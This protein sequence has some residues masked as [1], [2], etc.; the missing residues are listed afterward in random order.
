MQTSRPRTKR[1][2]L[3][4]G[5]V[6]TWLIHQFTGGTR[7][8]TDFTNAS[9][10]GLLN[11]HTLQWDSELLNLFGIP[12]AAMP[13]LHSTSGCFGKCVA[14]HE[15]GGVPILAA[16]GDS[17]AAMF[18]HG[19]YRSGSVKA[20]YGTGSSLMALA[21]SL[22]MDTPSLART[23]AWSIEGNTQFAL[24]GNIAMTGSAIQW[25]G[26]DPS[27]TRPCLRSCQTR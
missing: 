1:E 16:V 22:P 17:H 26:E 13:T 9:R 11:L 8:V 25:L 19:C 3:R 6:D 4:F 12:S 18:G 5:T 10:T 7:H 23:I 2:N 20:T 21:P 15:L 27:T 24:E 14:I